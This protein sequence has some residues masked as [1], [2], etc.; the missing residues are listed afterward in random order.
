MQAALDAHRQT[1]DDEALER[2]WRVDALP[3]QP[4]VRWAHA[5]PAAVTR[6]VA[7]DEGRSR[8]MAM[9][10]LGTDT[11]NATMAKAILRAAREWPDAR[12]VAYG[13]MAHMMLGGRYLYDHPSRE[14]VGARLLD[15]G[16]AR[17]DLAAVW[18]V[19]LSPP[20]DA[21]WPPDAEVVRLDGA[22]GDLPPQLLLDVPVTGVERVAQLADFAVGL[23]APAR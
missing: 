7:F 19:P 21:L 13:G 18:L 11:R 14:P 4:I 10:A 3:Y 16:F 23:R 5:H 22:A 8:V 6:V 1:R 12:I 17:G 2:A 15:E 20:L 9:R